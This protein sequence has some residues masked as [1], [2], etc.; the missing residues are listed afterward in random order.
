MFDSPLDWQALEWK[1]SRSLGDLSIRLEEHAHLVQ[2]NAYAR[3]EV[4]QPSDA[5]YIFMHLHWGN[6]SNSV[7]RLYPWAMLIAMLPFDTIL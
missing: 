4:Y 3:L 5:A 1:L 6:L 2:H 7:K